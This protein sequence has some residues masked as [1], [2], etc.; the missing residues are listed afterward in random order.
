MARKAL[1]RARK[2]RENGNSSAASSSCQVPEDMIESA[3]ASWGERQG[4][5][6]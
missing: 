5:L 6:F 2:N 3:E 4:E 1:E